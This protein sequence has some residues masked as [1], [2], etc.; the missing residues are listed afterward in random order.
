MEISVSHSRRGLFP[1]AFFPLSFLF[2][3]F[4]PVFKFAKWIIIIF[5]VQVNSWT[6]DYD[7]DAVVEIFRIDNFLV[8]INCIL[9][10]QIYFT[11][12]HAV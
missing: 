10:G 9:V 8:Y 3:I 7:G 5:L 12:F 6:D 11:F 2:F 4:Q 1:F